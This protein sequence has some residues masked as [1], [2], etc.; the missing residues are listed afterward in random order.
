MEPSF[1]AITRFS[2]ERRC[3]SRTSS[4]LGSLTA[5]SWLAPP[6]GRPSSNT[7]HTALF[8]NAQPATE[9]AVGCFPHLVPP[10]LMTQ[11]PSSGINSRPRQLS[12]LAC[13][14]PLCVGRAANR[15][16]FAPEAATLTLQPRE[17]SLHIYYAAQCSDLEHFWY[18]SHLSF[19]FL[20]NITS[21][22]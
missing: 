22:I 10:P 21:E 15:E 16:P 5:V 19:K 13:D 9:G 18:S 7:P 6:F 1:E 14:D 20:S 12:R 4:H 2:R 3:Y 8:G 11:A 17:L